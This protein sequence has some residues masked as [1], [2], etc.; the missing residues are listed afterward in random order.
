MRS[1]DLRFFSPSCVLQ[2]KKYGS[3]DIHKHLKVL[4]VRQYLSCMSVPE[5][6]HGCY[7]SIVL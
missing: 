5:V 6:K 4:H 2:L 3:L 1:S 7:F